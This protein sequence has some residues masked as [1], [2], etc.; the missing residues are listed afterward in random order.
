MSCFC[1][2]FSKEKG[3]KETYYLHFD[4][5]SDENDKELYLCSDWVTNFVLE[6]D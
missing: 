5:L 1:Q 2:E 4:E 3:L 6:Q